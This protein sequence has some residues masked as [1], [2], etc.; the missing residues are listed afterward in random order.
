MILGKQLVAII[1]VRGGSKGIPRK[2]LY[3][4]GKDTILERTIKLAQQNSAV[5]RVVV[6]TDD[7]EMFEISKKYNAAAP[8]LRPAHLATDNAKTIDVVLHVIDEMHLKDCYVLLLQTTSPLRSRSDLDALL[9]NFQSAQP[10]ADAIVSLVRH[11]SPHPMKI[12]KIEQG[13]VKS[14]MGVDS[15]VARQSLPEVFALN[16]AFYLT[17]SDVLLAQKTFMPSKTAA[18]VMPEERSVNLDN[19]KDLLLLEMLIEKSIVKIEEY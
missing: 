12:Q 2:N 17:H 1:P 14:L 11:D 19:Q 5:D 7:Q 6:S 9:A 13:Y 8:T 3:R 10:E 16:G 4:L 18:Y 15:M